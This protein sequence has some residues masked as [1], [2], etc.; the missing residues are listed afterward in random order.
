MPDQAFLGTMTEQDDESMFRKTLLALAFCRT[1]ELRLQ[2][3]LRIREAARRNS[4]LLREAGP[5]VHELYN[6]SEPAYLGGRAFGIAWGLMGHHA[7]RPFYERGS[8]ITARLGRPCELFF[9]SMWASRP[10][11]TFD[12]ATAAQQ[13]AWTA[14]YERRQRRALDKAWGSAVHELVTHLREGH[15]TTKLVSQSETNTNA[16]R[17]AVC[18]RA[19]LGAM[20]V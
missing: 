1:A 13:D 11:S 10:A 3:K 5:E 19:P 15:G 17:T 6:S 2:R 16:A 14:P 12:P 7:L 9:M 4:L 8:R 20:P 18:M